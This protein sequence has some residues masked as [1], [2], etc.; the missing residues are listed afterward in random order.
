MKGLDGLRGCARQLFC[1]ASKYLPLMKQSATIGRIFFGVAAIGSGVLQLARQDFVRLVPKLPGWLSIPSF[2]AVVTGAALVVAGAGLVFDRKR[3][4]AASILGVLLAVVFLLYLPGVVA[5]PGPGYMWTNPCK[6]LALIGGAILLSATG[7]GPASTRSSPGWHW[8]S[9]AILYG[10]FFILG[11]IQHFVY[12][13]FVTQ[14][15][16]E[17][18]PQ[19]RFW[20]G[21]AGI[22]LVLGGIGINLQPTARLASLL[23]GI[24]VLLWV[25]LLHIPR[26]FL[27][28]SEPGETA[29]IFEALAL[30]GVAFLLTPSKQGN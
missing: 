23:S 28:P 4:T 2:W 18:L 10:I 29:A 20:A 11:G 7:V 30:S 24:M 26:A 21:F 8:R 17:W 19:R 9:S 22:A 27:M 15:V 5:N 6:V 16:P 12:F 1:A 13:D 3:R 25:I 14:L